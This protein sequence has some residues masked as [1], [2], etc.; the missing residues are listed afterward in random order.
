MRLFSG[1][2]E[3][4]TTSPASSVS[5]ADRNAACWR[6]PVS[7]EVSGKNIACASGA[8]PTTP[9]L[10][11]WALMMPRHA[12]AWSGS[13]SVTTTSVSPGSVITSRSSWPS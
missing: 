12:V 4:E 8:M 13:V 3:Q 5:Y 7:T 1:P 2:N 10:F 9:L 11:S 6:G